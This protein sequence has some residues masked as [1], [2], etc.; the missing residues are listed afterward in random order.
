MFE[1]SSSK[2]C[3][4]SL[5]L[6]FGACHQDEFTFSIVEA[7]Y[8]SY[9]GLERFPGARQVRTQSD[10]IGQQGCVNGSF[11]LELVNPLLPKSNGYFQ[12]DKEAD[13]TQDPTL[14]Q[15]LLSTQW[16]LIYKHLFLSFSFSRSF[17]FS[18]LPPSPKDLLNNRIELFIGNFFSCSG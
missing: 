5:Q 6:R 3:S 17:L 15:E 4:A 8:S 11:V 14:L 16:N 13:K 1:T 18:F 12:G 7:S 9:I 10:T 2:N